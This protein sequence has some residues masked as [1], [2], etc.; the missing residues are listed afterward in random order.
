MNKNEVEL[1]NGLPKEM[2]K[3]MDKHNFAIEIGDLPNHKKEVIV[4]II[5]DVFLLGV[6]FGSN[7]QKEVE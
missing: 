1:L 2:E 5:K 3:I 7:V 4:N 6:E